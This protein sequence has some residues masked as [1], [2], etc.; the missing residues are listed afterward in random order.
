MAWQK[1]IIYLGQKLTNSYWRIA[2]QH[3]SHTSKTCRVTF[4][5][6]ADRS[7]KE[8]NLGNILDTHTYM[9]SGDEYQAFN[10]ASDVRMEA[11]VLSLATPD[12]HSGEV[13]ADNTPIMQSFFAGAVME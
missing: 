10:A 5:C 4:A 11:Y 1:S 7:A 8:S 6:Y 9:F 13:N 2:E 3:F 12:T